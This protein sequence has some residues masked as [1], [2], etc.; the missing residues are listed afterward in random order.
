MI[1]HFVRS[2]IDAEST[3]IWLAWRSKNSREETFGTRPY[4]PPVRF[5]WSWD[6]S[7]LT[8]IGIRYVFHQNIRESLIVTIAW[9]AGTCGDETHKINV[10]KHFLRL[11]IKVNEIGFSLVISSN[12]TISLHPYGNFA[13]SVRM[14]CTLPL[15]SVMKKKKCA[16]NST[17][18]VF[19]CI[20]REPISF[21]CCCCV[22]PDAAEAN[23]KTGIYA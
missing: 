8:A 15:L 14:P 19:R 22:Q 21:F 13:H 11:K 1:F 12:L 16:R 18:I 23:E 10:H 6:R 2:A 4:S 9:N 5:S 20:R 7:W 3:P 17:A